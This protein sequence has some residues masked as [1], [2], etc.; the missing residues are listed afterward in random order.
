MNNGTNWYGG[1]QSRIRVTKQYNRV[2]VLEWHIIPQLNANRQHET[3]NVNIP[4]ESH[5]NKY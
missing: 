5:Y 3:V 1:R 2:F 4:G